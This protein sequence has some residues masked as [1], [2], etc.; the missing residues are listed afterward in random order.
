[1]AAPVSVQVKGDVDGSIV[2]G[3]D[4]FVVNHN[5]GTIIYKQAAPQVR[6]RTMKPRPSRQVAA[7]LLDEKAL[8]RRLAEFLLRRFSDNPF[9][10]QALGEELGNLA[11]ALRAAAALGDWQTVLR[12]ARLLDPCLALHGLWDAWNG[13]RARGSAGA[14]RQ[15]LGGKPRSRRGQFS[16]Q[17]VLPATPGQRAGDAG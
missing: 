12:L 10:W 9:D 2:I 15:G 8:L 3:D 17:Y 4:N 6:P 1:M 13:D 7:R 11:G 16:R 5:H 14:R